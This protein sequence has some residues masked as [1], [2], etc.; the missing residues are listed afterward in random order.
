[1]L[2]SNEGSTMI[3]FYRY[4]KSSQNVC[5]D[6]P[7]YGS[8]LLYILMLPVKTNVSNISR[9][10][11]VNFVQTLIKFDRQKNGCYSYFL[12]KYFYFNLI[13]SGDGPYPYKGG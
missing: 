2:F 3:N 6:S 11:C 9:Q 4:I 13:L 10:F 7:R 1:M 12:K 8:I 5:M